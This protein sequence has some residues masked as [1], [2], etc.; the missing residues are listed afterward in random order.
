MSEDQF[1]K[2]F[3]HMQTEF[4]KVH[5]R[6]DDMAT[7]QHLDHITEMVDGIAK[8]VEDDQHERAALTLQVTRVED[9]VRALQK[10]LGLAQS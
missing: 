7:K 9:D 6:L 4:S 5:A 1:T 3:N 8:V 2:L 10:H